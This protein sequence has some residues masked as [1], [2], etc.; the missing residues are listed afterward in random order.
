M[1]APILDQ[2][3][4]TVITIAD[5]DSA[6]SSLEYLRDNCK[7]RIREVLDISLVNR[8]TFLAECVGL[9]ANKVTPILIG[10]SRYVTGSRYQVQGY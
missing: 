9:L 5:Y 4:D 1:L 6:M 2:D 3:W 7:G 10:N 8:P